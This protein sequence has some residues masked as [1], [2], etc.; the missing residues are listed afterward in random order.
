MSQA[1]LELRQVRREFPS[2]SGRITVLRDI[3]LSIH[4]GEFVAIMG[5]SGSGKSTL[6]NVLG[7]LDRPTAGSYRVNGIDT[8]RLDADALAQLRRNTFGFIFQRYNLM[9]DLSAVENAAIPAVYAGM[10]EVKR[11]SRAV[12]LLK[13]LG[14]GDRL[15]H[16]PSQLS[17]GQQQRVSIARALMNGA[18]TILADEPTG[19][20]DS[21]SGEEVLR[22]LHELH[23]LG[24]TIVLITHDEQIA[25]HAGRVVRLHDGRIVS[26]HLLN[27]GS[28]A[29][30]VVV[31]GNILPNSAHTP[32]PVVFAEALR[33]ALRSLLHNRLRTALTMLGIVIGVAS[34]VAMLA[35]GN[36][37]KKEV[38]ERIQAMGT[39]LLEIK[40]GLAAV[41]GSSKG[42]VTLTPEDLPLLTTLPG[43]AAAVPESDGT[44]VVRYGNKDL[45]VPAVGTS[46]AFPDVRNWPLQTGVFFTSADITGYRLVVAL[47]LSVAQELFPDDESPLGKYV[48]IGT[49]PF[50]I[51]GIMTAKGI[52]S[53]GYD[54]DY[55]VWIP[56]TTAS[57]LLFGRRYFEDV[58]VKV[59]HASLMKPV[60]QSIHTVLIRSHGEEDFNIRNMA[61]LI[62][63][64]N[65]TQNT[66]TNL[67]GAVAVI[68][69]IVGG[70][71]VMNIMLVSVTERTREIGIR[72]A[73]GARSFDV[74]LQFLTEAVVV[75][76]IGGIIGVVLGV[77]GGLATSR[78]MGWLTVISA[79]PG[80]LA[81]G[82]AFI[83]GIVF[84]FLPAR[85]A[86]RLDPVEALARD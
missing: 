5:Q 60:E 20:L 33:M 69:L 67:L 62:N 49:A 30:G 7:C 9:A 26:N 76:A 38:L 14:L 17:G 29:A 77:G 34:V 68:S 24:H 52:S 40:R 15:H 32:A 65:Q 21:R 50:Q 43:V 36:G 16:R 35:I 75:C 3:C 46:E 84:G 61:D 78:A 51:V 71:G 53:R 27:A 39:D 66:F 37:A 73:V 18:A 47:G 57:S 86:A 2:G 64:A 59:K 48:M 10:S 45:Q 4:A 42:V 80:V 82:C 25:Q 58:N 44:V 41:R 31:P 13:Q 28:V 74:L 19:A 81:F 63:T 72:M 23:R 85:K 54:L 22:T 8:A 11:T 12:E 79:T 55:Q 70:I 1:L 6:M 83:T 56:Y